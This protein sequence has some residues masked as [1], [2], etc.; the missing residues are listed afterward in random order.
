[1][2]PSVPVHVAVANDYEI[3]VEGTASVLGRFPDQIV[4]AER[5]VIG[6]EISTSVDVALYDTY[7]RRGLAE[8]ALRE[9]AAT[10][11][12]RHV[13]V[14]SLDLNEELIETARRAGATGFISKALSAERII[15]AIVAVAAGR[16]VVATAASTAPAYDELDW[17]GKDV[18]LSE[19]ESQVLVLVAEGLT[20]REVAEAMMLSTE[21]IK[22]YLSSVFTKLGLRNRVEATAYAHRSGAFRVY[23]PAGR[24]ID[25]EVAVPERA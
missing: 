15:E 11:Q 20:N 1:M 14:F 17:P 4:V 5:L 22:S 16:E 24:L 13:A 10:P 23:Q 3:V 12:V 21:T 9:L 19:R 25:G 2:N 7:G 6:E 8:P 18:G